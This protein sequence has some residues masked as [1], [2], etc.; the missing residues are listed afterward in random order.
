MSSK[1]FRIKPVNSL[2]LTMRGEPFLNLYLNDGL[3]FLYLSYTFELTNFSKL[4]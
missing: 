3:A 1:P 2:R 4:A